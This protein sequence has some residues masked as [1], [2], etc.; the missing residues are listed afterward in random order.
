MCWDSIKH[1][2]FPITQLWAEMYVVELLLLSLFVKHAVESLINMSSRLDYTHSAVA[3]KET[4]FSLE[5]A[6]S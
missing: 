3:P 4:V 2:P 1:G 5:T 6:T